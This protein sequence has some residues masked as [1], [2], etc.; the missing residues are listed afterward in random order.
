MC[1]WNPRSESKSFLRELSF[2]RA[3][4]PTRASEGGERREMMRVRGTDLF[5]LYAFKLRYGSMYNVQQRQ[6]TRPSQI[7]TGRKGGLGWPQR[8]PAAIAGI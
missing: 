2:L 8:R 3:D 5:L 4:L 6:T 7:V 1:P